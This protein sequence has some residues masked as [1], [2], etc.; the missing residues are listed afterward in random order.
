M[1]RIG[2]Y[3]GSFDPV[4]KGHLHLAEYAM[5]KLNLN[6]IILMPANISPFKQ[7]K[8]DVASPEHRLNM[9][10][11][12]TENMENV[13]VSSYELEN[14]GVSYTVCTLRHLKEMYTYDTLVLL[15]GS[16]MLLSFERWYC[17]QEIMEYA[18]LGCISRTD[19]DGDIL[20]RQAE[21]LSA[22]GKVSVLSGDVLPMSSTEIKSYL[23]KDEDCSCYLPE[24]VVQYIVRH[25]LYLTE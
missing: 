12:A 8:E 4:H 25:K 3:G 23:K 1:G 2:I 16:D 7:G 15:M 22:F 9:L 14:S 20:R 10:R 17:W 6:R 5:E 18:E 21:K 19:G 11:L 24:K 13:T